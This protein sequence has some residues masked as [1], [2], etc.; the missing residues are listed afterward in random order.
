MFADPP[1]PRYGRFCVSRAL[2]VQGRRGWYRWNRL[3]GPEATVGVG[4]FSDPPR[5]RYGRFCAH[6]GG[7]RG[8]A[9]SPLLRAAPGTGRPSWGGGGAGP[10]PRGPPWA[11]LRPSRGVWGGPRGSPRG[12][13]P[14][15]GPAGRGAPRRLQRYQPRPPGIPR[16][17]ARA[18]SA[19]GGPWGSARHQGVLRPCPGRGGCPSSAWRLGRL[20]GVLWSFPRKIPRSSV[21][22][23]PSP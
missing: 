6:A 21:G 23:F 12:G 14:R 10:V 5:L 11:E 4:V 8:S 17:R 13:S 9:G 3:A 16:G 1:R 15:V 18:V 20:G 2:G 19:L 7:P 22:F